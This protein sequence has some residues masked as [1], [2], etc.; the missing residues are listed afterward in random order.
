MNQIPLSI[1]QQKNKALALHQANQLAQ[2]QAIY[3]TLLQQTPHDAELWHRLGALYLQQNQLALAQDSLQKALSYQQKSPILWLHYGV[4]LGSL[5]QHQLAQQSFESGLACKMTVNQQV[6]LYYHHAI[7]LNK[8]QIIR[9]ALHSIAKVLQL[10]PHHALALNL[11]GTLYLQNQDDLQALNSY[12]LAVEFKADFA[13]AWYHCGIVLEK[14]KRYDEAVNHYQKAISLKPYYINALNNCANVL[15]GLQDYPQAIKLLTLLVEL[16]YPYAAG[17]LFY[18]KTHICDWKDYHATVAFLRQGIAQQQAVISP[19]EFFN[20]PASP[21]E[22][23]ICA[24]SYVIKNYPAQNSPLWRGE[25]YQHSKIKIAYISADFYNHATSILMIELFEQHDRAQFEVIALA[26]NSQHDAM[27][28]R[29]KAAFDKYIDVSQYTDLQVA[30]LIKSLQIDIAID[31]K[32]HTQDARLGIFAYKAAPIQV[33]YLG[34]ASTIGASYIDYILA[35]RHIAPPQYHADFSEKVVSLPHTYYVNDS[36]RPISSQI[37]SR[38]ELGLPETGFVFCCFNNSYKISPTMFDVWMR[39]LQQIPHSVLWLLEGNAIARQ[40]LCNEAKKCGVAPSRLVFAPKVSSSVHLARHQH[41]DLFLDTLPINAHTTACD[42]LWARVPIVTSMGQTFASRVAAS[43]LTA[44]GLPELITQNLTD[45]EAL[46]LKL[47]TS[48]LLLT[49][50][51][52]K[53]QHREQSPLFDIKVQRIAFESAYKKMY[54]RYQQGLV[55]Q[56]FNV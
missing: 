15:V 13:E 47:A 22:Q 55:P 16:N 52:Q 42:A 34:Q 14:L 41:A 4:V 53:L 28:E 37:F 32:G 51:K 23:L 9:P 25:I 40:N 5:N 48:P 11:Q 44:V 27:T 45:Y 31:L 33:N 6:D 54:Q 56:A 50:I 12:K 43:V 35:D 7:A 8:Q 20:V 18:L 2:A 30:Q 38:R 10:Q 39:L 46:A 19:F 29:I 24:E 36:K 26:F 3:Q 21:H 1:A 49:Q 17:R